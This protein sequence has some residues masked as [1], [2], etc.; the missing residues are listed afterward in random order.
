MVCNKQTTNPW[1]H[2]IKANTKIL[3]TFITSLSETV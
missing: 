3:G 2:N 1:K